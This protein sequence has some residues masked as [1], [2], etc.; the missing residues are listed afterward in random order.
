VTCVDRSNGDSTTQTEWIAGPTTPA[1]PATSAPP[2]T[3]AINPRVVAQQAEN[4]LRLPTPSLQFNPAASSVVNLP[5]WLWID[6]SIWH[7]FSVTATAGTVSATAVATPESVTWQMGDGGVVVCTGP[8]QP[9]DLARPVQQQGTLCD[10]AYRT[11]SLG[12]STPDGNPDAAAYLVRAT[13]TWAVTWT[14]QGAP[15]QGALPSLAT[16]GQAPVR[17]V[18]VES[19]NSGLF[20]LSGLSGSRTP[21][22]GVPS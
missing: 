17:V 6:P 5:T 20:G 3:P 8:G 10:Y 4:S 19:V 22:E 21:L 15:G 11:S 12:Q 7:Q 14:A 2:A 18:Q 9:F 16:A 13:V 1:T